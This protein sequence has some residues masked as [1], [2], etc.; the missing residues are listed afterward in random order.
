MGCSDT[1]E[2]FTGRK[3]PA[4]T[5]RQTVSHTFLE[6]CQCLKFL[7]VRFVVD[8][9]DHCLARPRHLFGYGTVGKQ[10]KLFNQVVGG[11]R[12]GEKDL[13]RIALLIE[14]EVYFVL[15]HNECA[16]LFS[17]AA[18]YNGKVIE[19]DEGLLQR[20]VR[21]CLAVQ[22]VLCLLVCQPVI[23]A[24]DGAADL[25]AHNLCLRSERKDDGHTE[26]VLVRTQRTQVVAQFFRQHRDN[27]VHKINAGRFLVSLPVNVIPGQDV[28]RH[29][30]YM[31]ADAVIA[32]IRWLK[33]QRIV[34]VLGFGG[35]NGKSE[36]LAEVATP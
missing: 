3:V 25:G 24:D 11:L 31:H 21:R 32:V 35:V 1:S 15:L 17:F 20:F 14:S 36:C 16:L 2:L 4:P 5:C 12:R 26:F 23:G 8:A 18:Q 29:I 33:R 6:S 13:N 34:K 7:F 30:G 9:I 28:M 19:R 27:A 10:H 22:Y